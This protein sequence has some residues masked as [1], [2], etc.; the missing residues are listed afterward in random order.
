MIVYIQPLEYAKIHLIRIGFVTMID[1]G[2]L[3]YVLMHKLAYHTS[4]SF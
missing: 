2:P 3:M 1:I 4:N